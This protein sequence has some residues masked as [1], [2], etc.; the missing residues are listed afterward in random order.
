MI[1]VLGIAVGV[2]MMIVVRAV[3]MGFEADFRDTLMGAKPH[4]LFSQSTSGQSRPWEEVLPLIRSSDEIRSATAYAGGLLFLSN[5]DYQT[6]AQVIGVSAED[7]PIHLRKIAAHL[8]VGSMDLVDGGIVIS[9]QQAQDLNLQLGDELSVYASQ[10]V[11]DAV[12]QYTE[13]NEQENAAAKKALVD[14]IRLNP[15]KLKLTGILKSESAGFLSYTTLATAQSLFHLGANV[16][17]IALELPDPKKAE[18]VAK[19]LSASLPDWKSELWSDGESARLAAMG[20]E[21]TMM[22]F[23]LSIIALVAA[24]SV[25]NTTITITT[26]KRR[27]IGVIAAIGG[28]PV[29]IVNVFLLQAVIVGILGT[30]LGLGGS[31]MVLWLRND[32]RDFLT[33]LAG[34]QVHAVDGVF[35]SSIPAFLQPWD[36][37]MTCTTS[38]LLC[39]VAGFIPAWFAARV[40]P[41]VALRD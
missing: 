1:S 10:N 35:L 15:Q 13:A 25:M 32:L 19:T 14:K 17:G 5:G 38:I 6:G 20:N 28:R 41:A 30:G 24:F 12:R 18:A 37:I 16:T 34:G 7:A 23:V 3:M 22:Q 31:L 11:N 21:Q 29:Q 2:L 40:D 33:T 4:I 36:V 8:D 39:I 26:Q 27:E 9:D